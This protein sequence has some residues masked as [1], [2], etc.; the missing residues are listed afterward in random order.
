MDQIC[1]PVKLSQFKVSDS[2]WGRY[3]D[4][5]RNTVI[6]YQWKAINDLIEGAP[7]SH[8]MHNFKV[9]AGLEEGTFEGPVFQDHDWFTWIEAV[10]YVL[11]HDRDPELEKVA[12][13]SIDIVC[14][15]QQ[16]DGYLNTYYIINGLEKR[17]TNLMDN[18]ELFNLGHFIE[19]AVAYYEAT[20]KEK[21][22][23]AAMKYADLACKTFGPEKKS[24][25]RL[26]RT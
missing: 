26:P 23:K 2:F 15:A 5:V 22:L 14:A 25:P 9:A 13:E 19:G 16:E 1:K 20:G 10:G 18:H 24:I 17:W 12:D 11:S 6:P 4:L 3:L 21:I 8:S 7:P